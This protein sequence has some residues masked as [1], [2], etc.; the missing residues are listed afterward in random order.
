MIDLMTSFLGKFSSHERIDTYTSQLINS[1]SRFLP[2]TQ[3]RLL[4]ERYLTQAKI[5]TLWLSTSSLLIASCF[6]PC[7]KPVVSMGLGILGTLPLSIALLKNVNLYAKEYSKEIPQKERVSNSAFLIGLIFIQVIGCAFDKGKYLIPKGLIF[8]NLTL[9]S[10]LLISTSFIHD[11]KYSNARYIA[12]EIKEKTPEREAFKNKIHIIDEFI[13]ARPELYKICKRYAEAYPEDILKHTA[14]HM[15]KEL[16][17][18]I[19]A[20]HLCILSLQ[21]NDLKFQLE[22]RRQ[23]ILRY[24]EVQKCFEKYLEKMKTKNKK[25]P[26]YLLINFLVTGPSRNI[27]SRNLPR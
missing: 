21:V 13:K 8:S 22:Q 20:E 7:L 11:H 4:I 17:P 12:A 27:L 1:G 23:F 5:S 14:E 25:Y 18:A 2:I 26:S 15:I 9:A 10:V 16:N 24:P 19:P 6:N 3:Q